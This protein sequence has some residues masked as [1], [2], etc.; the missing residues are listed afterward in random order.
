M[1]KFPKL[2]RF[3]ARNLAFVH[4]DGGKRKLYLGKW[5]APET[6]AAYRRFIAELAADVSVVASSVR[7]EPTE[8]V[9]CVAELADRAEYYVKNGKQ[10]GQ[11]DRFRAALEFPLRYFP[12]TPV[13]D[14]G[15][16]KLLFC[17]DEMEKSGRFARSY[18]NT[19]VNCFR[20]VVKWGVG[21]ELVRPETLVALQTVPALKRGKSTTREFEPVEL[22][23]GDDV[24]ATLPF[25]PGQVAAMVRIQRLTGMRPGEVCAMRFGDVET[26][27]DVWVYVLRSDKTDWRRAVGAKK[28]VPLGPQ[29]QAILAPYLAE[30]SGDRDAFLFS[31][32]AAARDRAFE[33][34]RNRK[35]PLTPSQRKRDAAPKTRRYAESYSSELYGKIVKKAAIRAGVEPWTPNRLRR[36]YATEVRAKFGLEAAQIMLGHARADVTQIYAER[37]FTKAA[38]IAAEIG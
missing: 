5:G 20:S 14:F 3:K 23:P 19:L 16:K 21:R 1:K 7:G 10:T 33:R 22:V 31:P 32:C 30:K 27:G 9:V 29:V 26:S 36:L 24:D 38:Q 4:I 6:E 8:R 37:D 34:R 15:P 28:R 2:C 11:L 13:D 25:L 18:V 17:R 35:T 12:A